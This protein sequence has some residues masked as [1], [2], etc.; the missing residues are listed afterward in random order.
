MLTVAYCR[1]STEEQAAE[2]FSI[3]GQ[4]DRLRGYAE[5][6]GLG[7]VTVVADPGWSGKDLMRPGLQQL[8]GMVEAGHV[9]DVLLWRLDRLSRSLADLILL[10]DKCGQHGVALH[11]FTEKLDL[12]SAT[13]RMFYNILGSFAQFYREQLSE[14]V[15]MGLHQAAKQGRWVNRPKTGY[16]LL[17]GLLVPN[18]DAHRVREIFRLR[19]EG[20]SH[21]TIEERTGIKYSTVGAILKS[22]I[23]LGEVQHKD[24]WFP[25]LHEPI[26]TLEEFEAAS[27]GFVK[28]RR[29][30]KDLL[31]GRVFCGLC[32]R[33]M[34]IET[35]GDGRSMYRCRHRGQGCK[36]PRRTNSGLLRAAVLG[37][38]L[39]GTDQ[40]LQEAIRKQLAGGRR[41]EPRGEARR[42][43]RRRPAESLAAL[44]E[45]RRKLLELYY[46]DQITGALF[47]E[48]EGLIA[49]QIEATHAEAG[50][51]EQADSERD[52]LA[53]RF[54]QVVSVLSTLDIDQVWVEATD[55]ERRVLLDEL[56][57][58]VTIFPDHIEVTVA[59]SPVLNVLFEEVGLAPSQNAGVGGGT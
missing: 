22:R 52:G 37:L 58:R 41:S 48:E 32:G 12:S 10:A 35:N 53:L 50:R 54:E 51:E 39:I 1:V 18:E 5:L 24:E 33:R 26:V 7:E 47:K 3:E 13:G 4:A 21:T 6:H 28:G 15:R 45:R 23:Y 46:Q 16:D 30:G 49:S 2:G 27:R 36:Q 55:L 11:S 43:S 57:D 44:T 29:R 25:G 14:N 42:R 59:G 34:P 20:A 8:L 40:A 9:S 31:S 56:M 38:R 19:A 17:E